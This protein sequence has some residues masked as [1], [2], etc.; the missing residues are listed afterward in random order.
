MK[1]DTVGVGVMLLLFCIISEGYNL[2][3]LSSI[4]YAGAELIQPCMICFGGHSWISET[5]LT[6]KCIFEL[7]DLQLPVRL[8]TKLSDGIRKD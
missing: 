7:D 1:V 6:T 5:P 8:S 3:A 2:A 4:P